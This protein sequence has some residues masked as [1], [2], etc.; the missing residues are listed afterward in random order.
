VKQKIKPSHNFARA[1]YG[2]RVV[3]LA[4]GLVSVA[5]VL[6]TR[7]LPWWIWIGPLLH[8]IVWPHL[9]W[10]WASRSA[11]AARAERRNLLIDHFFGG[12]WIAV[13]GFNVL[14]SVLMV[15]LMGMD[16]MIAGGRRQFIRGMLAHAGGA[17]VGVLLYGMHWQPESGPSQVLACLPLLLLHPISV[18]QITYRALTKLK[19]QREEL[20]HLSQ[21][22]GLTDLYNRRHWE[23]MVKLEFARFRRSGET[24]TLVLVDLDHFKR[25]NDTLGHA[26]G[27]AVLR[28]FA[29]RLRNNL[30]NTDTP[31]R[32]GGEEFGILLPYTAAREAGELM[33]RLQASLTSEPLLP[34]RTVTASFGVAALSKDLTSHEA[35]MRLADQMLYR[36]K[37]RGRDC[38]VT[39]GDSRPS[40]LLPADGL[41]R[42]M[43]DD[44]AAMKRVLAGLSLGDIGAVLFDPSDRLAWANPVFLQ[45]YAVQPQARC[46]GDIMRH[47]HSQQTGPRIETEDID[48]WLAVADAKRRS[49]PRRSFTIDM[50][51]GRYFRV[52]EMSFDDGWLLDLLTEVSAERAAPLDPTPVP[53]VPQAQKTPPGPT[54]QA[55]RTPQAQP[56]SATAASPDAVRPG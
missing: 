40:P 33:Q 28:G 13:M 35:W 34:Q 17:A 30:R 43:R 46:F 22:D 12:I 41:Q 54:P 19:R 50:V 1:S 4:L 27:D 51:D 39:A 11:E 55:P 31:G 49:G 21:H 36:A 38:V 14:P 53:P 48:A 26:A 32:Y 10:I 47:C 24:A 5:G 42:R 15:T 2:P 3:G 23:N 6:V 29:K 45:L 25:V 37:D 20:A 9:A 18:G 7:D 44:A 16:S 8:G 56:A 52:E